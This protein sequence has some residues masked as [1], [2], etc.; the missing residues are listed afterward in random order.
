MSHA[1]ERALALVRAPVQ[2]VVG[3]QYGQQD[4]GAPRVE[5]VEECEGAGFAA[6]GDVRHDRAR[7]GQFGQSECPPDQRGRGLPYVI[8]CQPA[9]HR[10]D[11]PAPCALVRV[12]GAFVVFQVRPRTRRNV[13]I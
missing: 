1:C 10:E 8:G 5:R 11:A 3:Q 6:H 13:L 4:A 12:V 2:V 7:V 9:A